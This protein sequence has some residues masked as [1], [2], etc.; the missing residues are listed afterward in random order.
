MMEEILKYYS[1]N[2]KREI[3]QGYPQNVYRLC[4]FISTSLNLPCLELL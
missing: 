3:I 2:F 1:P 4:T